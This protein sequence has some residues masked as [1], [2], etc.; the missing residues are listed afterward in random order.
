[1]NG[2]SLPSP[3]QYRAGIQFSRHGRGRRTFQY[4]TCLSVIQIVLNFS[5]L[6]T[7]FGTNRNVIYFF[8]HYVF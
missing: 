1:M 4:V 2:S 3:K 6:Q 7:Q 5:Q 8:V